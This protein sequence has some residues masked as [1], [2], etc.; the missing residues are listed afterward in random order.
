VKESVGLDSTCPIEVADLSKGGAV[1]RAGAMPQVSVIVATY[2]MGMYVVEAVN[3]VLAQLVQDLEVIVVDD[4]STDG[5]REVLSIFAN[6][7]RVRLLFQENQGQP[8]AKNSGL[9]LAR[10][11]FIAFCD[12]DDYWLPNKLSLQLPLFERNPRVGVVYSKTLRLDTDGRVFPPAESQSIQPKGNVLEHLFIRNRVPFGTAVVR[13]E[14]LQQ[15]KGFDE[16]I[17]MGIDWDLWL[18]T[19]LYWEFDCVPEATYVYRVWAGQM[20]NNWRGRYQCALS[21]MERF[22]AANPGRLSP[23]LVATAFADTYTNLA[24]A[25]LQQRP[26]YRKEGLRHVARALSYRLTFWPA[27]RLLLTMPVQRVAGRL[28]GIIKGAI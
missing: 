27:W 25:C 22:L 17:P 14:C 18:R 23:Q 8:K 19:A 28:R 26:P 4:G 21:I 16:T 6:N 15:V 12:A 2:N 9:R 7:P 24:D 20:S 5:T 3:S 13:R 10:G 11:R 1:G